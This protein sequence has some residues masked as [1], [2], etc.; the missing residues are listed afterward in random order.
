MLS[1]IHYVSAVRRLEE[2]EKTI[3]MMGGSRYHDNDV[4]VTLVAQRDMV[5]REIEYYKDRCET[6]LFFSFM[7]FIFG[8]IGLALYWRIYA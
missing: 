4:P 2:I 1:V 8:S 6:I 5:K 7:I 3:L